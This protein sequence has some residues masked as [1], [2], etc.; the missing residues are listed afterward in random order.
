MASYLP[1]ITDSPQSLQPVGYQPDYSFLQNQLQRSNQAYEQGLSQVHNDF[2]S[3][4]NAP[5]TGIAMQER[6]NQ[7]I[8]N[9]KQG[10]KKVASS[11]LSIPQNVQQAET[12]FAPFWQDDLLL[13]NTAITKGYQ[14]ELGKA[15]GYKYNKD[16]EVRAMYN[17]YATEYLQQGLC[18]L[19]DTPLT[20]EAYDRVDKRKFEPFADINADIEQAWKSYYGS[21][22]GG[23]VTTIDSDGA[24]L[25]TT[26]NGVKSK[27]AFRTWY[28]GQM[29]NKYDTQLRITA[30]VKAQ[31][32]KDAIIR[33]NPELSEKELNQHFASDYL[34]VMEKQITGNRDAYTD[35]ANGWTKKLKELK[36]Q[37]DNNQKGKLRPE[38]V[39]AYN[40]YKNQEA[41][42]LQ[43]ANQYQNA[44]TRMGAGNRTSEAALKQLHN[45]S[46]FPEDYIEGIEKNAMAENWAAGMASMSSV[47]K[48]LDPVWSKYQELANE[49]INQTLRQREIDATRRGQ[50]L[51]YAAKV[52][53][54]PSGIH[55]KGFGADGQWHGVGYSET[56]GPDS[57][58]IIGLHATDVAHIVQG[59]DIVQE[60]QTKN[61][62]QITDLIYSPKG[63]SAI[64]QQTGGLT[65]NE[66]VDFTEAMKNAQSGHRPTTE[67]QVVLDKVKDIMK[68]NGI[69]YDINSPAGMSTALL[70]YSKKAADILSKSDNQDQQAAGDNL[71]RNYLSVSSKRDKMLANKKLFDETVNTTIF[72]DKKFDKLVY[73]ENGNKRLLTPDDMANDF[74]DLTAINL[75]TRRPILFL[76]E[77][78]AKRYYDGS[79][80]LGP[81]G[82]M[83][84][85]GK[86]YMVAEDLRDEDGVSYVDGIRNLVGGIQNYNKWQQNIT[87]KYGASGVIAGLAKSAA[88]EAIPKLREYQDGLISPELA[89]NPNS[90]NPNE[91]KYST[92]LAL[93]AS[94][95]SNTGIGYTFDKNG[96]V[97]LL[98]TEKE[99][100]VRNIL[101]GSDQV[102]DL[103]STVIATRDST[104]TPVIAIHF[105]ATGKK[106]E[107]TNNPLAG[108]TVYLPK[109]PNATGDY[110][111][112]ISWDAPPQVYGNILQGETWSSD[113]IME[114][115]GFVATAKGYDKGPD[116]KATKV[117]FTLKRRIVDLNSG[118]EIL[119]P[120][121][122]GTFNTVGP[123]A[124]TPD[125]IVGYAQNALVEHLNNRTNTNNL[126]KSR[127]PDNAPTWDQVSKQSN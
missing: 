25:I 46:E 60:I 115:A 53:Q 105:V 51:T 107:E 102:K 14:N 24:A 15:E 78:L 75:E 56:A 89:Y 68:G 35:Q 121:Q 123:D 73:I 122:E 44:Y 100:V 92:N 23:G 74:Q 26:H 126:V 101:S 48:E 94:S 7:Y 81:S 52:G 98:S 5:V 37:V 3:I 59:L 13:Q 29:G 45:L 99:Q 118:K 34:S 125:Y 84:I 20:K 1:Q 49:H 114:S 36:E 2:S 22:G 112:A 58:R 88:K 30:S 63:I 18:K 40:Y 71:L 127:V 103:V 28:L 10:L 12:A 116:G 17:E 117:L 33:Q 119:L 19:A 80:D 47:K 61:F 62:N 11:D 69:T 96:K 38:Q 8:N 85:D 55:I 64:L 108:K 79:L 83:F 93:E 4:L 70:E 109:N 87:K 6:K 72:S 67:Q 90:T 57:G 21:N 91:Q 106:G 39:Q 111:N 43:A 65:S 120:I 110:I 42:Y 66:V 27:D 95:P 31:R 86:K 16:P 104:N 124:K 9:A 41:S 76:K 50:D 32:A 54:T 77:E 113:P 82:E 97:E